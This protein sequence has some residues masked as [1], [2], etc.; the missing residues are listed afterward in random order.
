ML[1]LCNTFQDDNVTL[2]YLISDA[3]SISAH[4][5]SDTCICTL[6]EKYITTSM[7]DAKLKLNIL[8]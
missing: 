3:C 1:V 2:Q 8:V 7:I 6:S 4:I 5:I